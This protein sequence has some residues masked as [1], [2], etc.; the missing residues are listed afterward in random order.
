MTFKEM[1]KNLW[2]ETYRQSV[3]KWTGELDRQ[4]RS[5]Y[6]TAAQKKCRKNCKVVFGKK[7]Y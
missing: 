3:K 1:I 4:D 5:L 6:Q 2:I 7:S